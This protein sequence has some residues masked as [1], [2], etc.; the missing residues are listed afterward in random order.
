MK[1]AADFG[2]SPSFCAFFNPQTAVAQRRGQGVCLSIDC[3]SIYIYAVLCH[4][5]SLQ[6]VMG[7][8]SVS[9]LQFPLHSPLITP[10]LFP[11]AKALNTYERILYKTITLLLFSF[12]NLAFN[13]EHNITVH[14]ALTTIQLCIEMIKDSDRQHSVSALILIAYQSD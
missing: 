2:S 9:N 5:Y 6:K 7:E 10:Q 13:I 14:V 1:T 3:Y 4:K 8:Q 11:S 12:A